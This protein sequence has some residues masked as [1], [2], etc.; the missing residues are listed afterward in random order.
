MFQKKNKEDEENLVQGWMNN[1]KSRVKQN[2]V[3]LERMQQLHA[4]WVVLITDKKWE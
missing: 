3:R 1:L 2:F 4:V